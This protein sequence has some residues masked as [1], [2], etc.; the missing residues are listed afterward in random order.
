ME[1]LGVGTRRDRTMVKERSAEKVEEKTWPPNWI[2]GGSHATK[3]DRRGGS[4]PPSSM[5]R[6]F[7]RALVG[8]ATTTESVSALLLTPLNS[9]FLENLCAALDSSHE[10]AHYHS[11]E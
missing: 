2:M 10:I 4:F 7:F 11:R 5:W 8:G 6:L 3:R 9:Y 1:Q